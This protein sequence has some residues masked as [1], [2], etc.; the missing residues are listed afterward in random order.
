MGIAVD[1]GG[2]EDIAC[3]ADAEEVIEVHD[4][5]ILGNAVKGGG[6]ASFFIMEVGD[7]G[8]ST[9]AIGV[10]DVA[11]GG[12]LGEVVWRNFAEGAGK[13]AWVK[14]INSRVDLFFGRRGSAG[15]VACFIF[16]NIKT[17]DK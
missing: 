12:I 11:F 6:V 4:D 16:H 15:F 1:C 3:S 9:G 14:F 5:R 8:F 10:D 13:E 7:K 2:E 17:L